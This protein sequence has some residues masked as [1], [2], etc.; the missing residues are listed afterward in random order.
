MPLVLQSKRLS[1]PGAAELDVV[2]ALFSG[3]GT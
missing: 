1:L 3:E 2:D